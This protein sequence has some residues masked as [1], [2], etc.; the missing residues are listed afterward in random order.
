MIHAQIHEPCH[1]NLIRNNT[2]CQ[3]SWLCTSQ[4]HAKAMVC[5]QSIHK[6]PVQSHMLNV[7][8]I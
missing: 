7:Q 1:P 8:L 5:K 6:K 2:A 3:V 4:T